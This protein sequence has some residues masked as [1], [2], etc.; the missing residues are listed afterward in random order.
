[1]TDSSKQPTVFDTD[2]QQLGDVY[3]KALLGA[4]AKSGSADQLVEELK[5][6][7]D[8]V[9]ELPKMA[10]ALESP[11]VSTEAK[12]GLLEKAFGDKVSKDL[13]NFLKVT[14]SKGRLDCL[15][16]IS[17]SAARLNDEMAGRIAGTLTTAEPITDDVVERVAKKI[18]GQIGKEVRLERVVDPEIIGGMVVRVGDTVYDGSVVSQLNQVKVRAAKRAGDIIREK[19]EQFTSG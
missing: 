14:A 15:G 6:V 8:A 16:A 3:A 2:Q 4:G 18:S 19:L 10:S 11:R 5:A 17:G 9:A 13:L 7:A 1:M 12:I